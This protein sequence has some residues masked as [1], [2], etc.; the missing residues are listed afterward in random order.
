MPAETT[1]RFC[2]NANCDEP[3]APIERISDYH[4]IDGLIICGGCASQPLNDYF[5]S[6]AD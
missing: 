3:D 1:M 4:F 5:R 2:E 6:E